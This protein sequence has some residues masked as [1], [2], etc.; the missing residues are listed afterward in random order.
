MNGHAKEDVAEDE[1]ERPVSFEGFLRE[2][3]G[4]LSGDWLRCSLDFVV[5]DFG[6]GLIELGNLDV[7][8][9]N[10][11]DSVG[12]EIRG[13]GSDLGEGFESCFDLLDARLA[14]HAG[15]GVGVGHGGGVRIGD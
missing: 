2:V 15:D 12:C 5:A 6:E 10:N 8:G 13:G 14:G 11:F 9:H 3:G 7:A 4:W 1:D